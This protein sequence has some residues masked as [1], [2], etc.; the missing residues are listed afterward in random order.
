MQ[1][2]IEL[3]DI[4]S[5]P[6]GAAGPVTQAEIEGRLER[7]AGLVEGFAEKTALP[8]LEACLAAAVGQG[9]GDGPPLS[10]LAEEISRQTATLQ[11]EVERFLSH[12]DGCRQA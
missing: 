4:A 6:L 12:I 9:I 2:K 3:P 8:A 5:D 10:T 11:D 1:P 7:A